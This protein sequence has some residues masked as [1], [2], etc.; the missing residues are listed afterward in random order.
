MLYSHISHIL[1]VGT[2]PSHSGINN[3][4]SNS[5]ICPSEKPFVGQ[6]E[7]GITKYYSRIF[8]FC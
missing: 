4:N 2:D 8:K 3:T 1:F 5:F 7:T 6:K